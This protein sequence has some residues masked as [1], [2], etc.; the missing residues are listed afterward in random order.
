MTRSNMSK[1]EN[2]AN[3]LFCSQCI[4]HIH[5]ELENLH[6]NHIQNNMDQFVG[7]Q[8]VQQDYTGLVYHLLT[9]DLL[10]NVYLVS[11]WFL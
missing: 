2:L 11:I 3:Y 6:N 5:N 7:E 10:R 4:W 9:G 8:V 1:S